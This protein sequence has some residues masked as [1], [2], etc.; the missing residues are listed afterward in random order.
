MFDFE[1]KI[2]LENDRVHLEPLTMSHLGDLLP[3]GRAHPELVQ[4]SPIAIGNIK[5]LIAFIN[6]TI[7]TENWYGFVIFDKQTKEYAGS[8]SYLNVSNHK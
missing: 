3:I 6:R 8:T 7:Q 5:K 1:E 2:V 4:Y